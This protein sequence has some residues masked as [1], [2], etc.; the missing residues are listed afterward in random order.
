MSEDDS[1]FILFREMLK[2]I[3]KERKSV[4]T[5]FLLIKNLETFVLETI[6]MPNT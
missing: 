6:F 3:E 4:Y 2:P 1:K 5:L